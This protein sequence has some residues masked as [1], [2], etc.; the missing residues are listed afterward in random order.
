MPDFTAASITSRR[1]AIAELQMLAVAASQTI[2]CSGAGDRKMIVLYNGNDA[3][4]DTATITINPGDGYLAGYPQ[5]TATYT[6][7]GGTYAVLL[8]HE[9]A[10]FKNSA[11]KMTIGV[12]V[13]HSGTL[14]N[15]KMAII[16]L[17]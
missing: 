11:G 13:T 9:Y 1:N 5:G 3:N 12:A 17:P 8:P 7:N 16:N 6:I 4:T 10:K 14:S 2:D 15:V